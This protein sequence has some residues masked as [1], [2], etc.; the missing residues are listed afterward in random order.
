MYKS[1]RSSY[2]TPGPHRTA[3]NRTAAEATAANLTIARSGHHSSRLK[4]D[5][6]GGDDGKVRCAAGSDEADAAAFVV[7]FT[8]HRSPLVVRTWRGHSVVVRR[9]PALDISVAALP[10]SHARTHVRSTYARLRRRRLRPTAQGTTFAVTHVRDRAR[11]SKVCPRCA[12]LLYVVMRFES[13]SRR[14][15]RIFHTHRT[16]MLQRHFFSLLSV[17]NFSLSHQCNVTK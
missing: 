7:V 13:T 14:R 1:G 11:A 12:P 6:S 15:G 4:K 5:V 8:V 10:H 17:H 9:A 2:S 3:Q 16:T